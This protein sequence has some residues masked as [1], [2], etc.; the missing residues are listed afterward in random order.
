MLHSSLLADTVQLAIDDRLLIL[1]SAAD[2]FVLEAARR[3]SA[4]ELIL[5]EDN[6]ASLMHFD[7]LIG[8]PVGADLSRPS[9]IMNVNTKTPPSVGADLSRPSPI[10]RPS[11][12]LRVRHVPFHEYTLHEAPATIDVAA[13]NMLYQPG[14]AW[15]IYGL[16]VAAYAL[17]PGDCLYVVGAK[18]RGVLSMAK[19]MQSLF[20][21]METL[22]ISKG[23]RVICSRK[24]N[25]SSAWRPQGAPLHVST[26]S[27][28]LNVVAPLAG[29]RSTNQFPALLPTVFAEGKLDEGTRLLLE[30]LEVHATDV[31]LDIGCGAGYI[32][33]HIARLASKGH[34][35]MVDASL[36]TVEAARRMVEQSGLTNVQVLASDGTKALPGQR[37]DLVA[38][39]P[40]FH[41]GGIQT[42]EIGERFIREAAQVLRPRG[43]LYLVA[44]RFLKYEPT[45]RACFKSVEEVGGNTRYKVLRAMTPIM[46]E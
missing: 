2:P 44:N 4:G 45:L 31:A 28:A 42:T 39:N 27:N 18:D 3:L 7:R 19:R 9:P 30:A 20:G 15:M 35:T 23:Q 46:H 1:N 5:A 34:V 10:Y 17:K 13:M 11:A 26:T 43:R 21:N 36:A 8:T 37:F 14:N 24:E 16:H 33:M 38:T 32:G 25:N 40:P 41:L 22:V 6:I 29:A 12:Q